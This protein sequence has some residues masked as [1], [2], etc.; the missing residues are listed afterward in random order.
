MLNEANDVNSNISP[1]ENAPTS[2]TTSTEATAG[3]AA[4]ENAPTAP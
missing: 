4:A 1:S 2:G 3:D